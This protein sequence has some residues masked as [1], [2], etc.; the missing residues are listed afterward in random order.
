MTIIQLLQKTIGG[1]VNNL[2][3]PFNRQELRIVDSITEY[4]PWEALKSKDQEI[5]RE[6]NAD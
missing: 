1:S 3:K 5:Q 6:D 4:K 2:L